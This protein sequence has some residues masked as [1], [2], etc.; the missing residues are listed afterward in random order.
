MVTPNTGRV[1]LKRINTD[2]TMDSGLIMPG[3]L[4]AG[5]NL[6]VGE[7]VH[8]GT[9]DF[10]IGQVV[11][12]S[13]YSAASLKDMGK[14]FRKEKTIGEMSSDEAMFVVAEDDIMAYEDRDLRVPQA[15]KNQPKMQDRSNFET[16]KDPEVTDPNG[17]MILPG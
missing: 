17:Q 1:L 15:P 10:V 6:F 7:V 13:E 4:K 8:P 16:K 9:T 12:F 14:L 5:E 3:Q 2:R 11:Y